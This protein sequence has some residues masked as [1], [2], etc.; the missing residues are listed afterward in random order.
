MLGSLQDLD[1]YHLFSQSQVYFYILV[2]PD[3]SYFS[4][5][6]LEGDV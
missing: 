3:S 1:A 2:Q 5:L 4:R 6:C